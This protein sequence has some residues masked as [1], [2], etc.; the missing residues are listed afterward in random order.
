VSNNK[1]KSHARNAV[2]F[3]FLSIFAIEFAAVAL[4]AVLK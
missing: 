1:I 2:A 4:Q 3:W